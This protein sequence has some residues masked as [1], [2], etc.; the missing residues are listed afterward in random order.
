MEVKQ[1]VNQHYGHIVVN[2]A[3]STAESIWGIGYNQVS[4]LRTCNWL[5][6]IIKQ[7]T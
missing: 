4:E 6:S 3:T 1:T 2:V 5:S 7:H